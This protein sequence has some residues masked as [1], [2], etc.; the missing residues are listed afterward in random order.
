MGKVTLPNI[1]APSETQKL[2]QHERVIL[3]YIGL[4]LRDAEI[5]RVLTRSIFTVRTHVAAIKRVLGV[6]RREVL[7]IVS[8][9]ALLPEEVQPPAK[10]AVP[11]QLVSSFRRAADAAYQPHHRRS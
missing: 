11:P 3:S 5:A 9:D 4:G 7:V 10:A 2:T 8:R 6:Q 1:P